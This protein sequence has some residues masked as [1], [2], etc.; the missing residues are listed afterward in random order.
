[1]GQPIAGTA[2]LKV[3]GNQYP[4]K[5]N[6]TVS[7][8]AVDRSG[9][10]GQDAVHGFQELPRVP[11][12]E[13]DVSTLAGLSLEEIE[14]VTDATVTAEL[15]NGSVY[16]LRNAWTKAAFEVNTHDGQFRVRFE[17]ISCD[18]IQ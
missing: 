7:P 16:V 18:E 1:M 2:Y 17:G 8:S 15:R 9:I 14:Q 11:Y 3:D 5:G 6:F 12:I 10:A 4:L 13:G